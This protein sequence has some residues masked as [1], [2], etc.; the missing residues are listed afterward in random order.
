MGEEAIRMVEEQMNQ[1]HAKFSGIGIRNVNERIK[2]EFGERYGV[3]LGNGDQG[4]VQATVTLPL[5]RRSEADAALV[6]C[7]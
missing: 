6:D 5:R 7:G 1:P 3:V 4:G 2:L